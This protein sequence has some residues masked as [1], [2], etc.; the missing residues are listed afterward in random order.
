METEWVLIP[1]KE[2]MQL[3][4]RE[5]PLKSP[6]KSKKQIKRVQARFAAAIKVDAQEVPQKNEESEGE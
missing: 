4:L 6:P 1:A 5:Q 3:L 2:Y